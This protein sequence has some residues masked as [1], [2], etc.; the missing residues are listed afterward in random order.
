MSYSKFLKKI[1]YEIK[2]YKK[3]V[4]TFYCDRSTK[5]E[6]GCMNNIKQF[7]EQSLSLM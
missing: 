6:A 1:L 3:S 2:H 4:C 5:P 7:E